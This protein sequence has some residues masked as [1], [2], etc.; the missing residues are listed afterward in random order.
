MCIVLGLFPTFKNIYI[1]AT[2]NLFYLKACKKTPTLYMLFQKADKNMYT[3][4][5]IV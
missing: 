1:F 5:P 4:I 2:K 3:P